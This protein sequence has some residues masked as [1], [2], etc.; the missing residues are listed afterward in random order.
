MH[1]CKASTV[2][3]Q[4]PFKQTPLSTTAGK[5]H[6]R[7]T[8]P[9]PSPSLCPRRTDSRRQRGKWACPPRQSWL[10]ANPSLQARRPALCG[11]CW[12]PG[13][14]PEVRPQ[15]RENAAPRRA[16]PPSGLTEGGVPF[17]GVRDHLRRVC[18]NHGP[19]PRPCK[20]SERPGLSGVL[21][22]LG[23]TWQAEVNIQ[24]REK[25]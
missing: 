2:P 8:F 12:R 5:F 11:G 17:A 1:E 18:Y 7:E 15:K 19:L 14:S 22:H 4:E 9:W 23:N 21:T 24:E 10:L 16:P 25:E 3:R 20:P 6:L 13:L